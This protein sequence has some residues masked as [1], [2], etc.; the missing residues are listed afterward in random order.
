MIDLRN[1]LAFIQDAV[2]IEV[3]SQLLQLLAAHLFQAL[4]AD[5]V[6]LA[7]IDAVEERTVLVI[8]VA[9]TVDFGE[10]G[11]RSQEPAHRVNGQN[12][13]EHMGI[14]VTLA[15]PH[16]GRRQEAAPTRCCTRQLVADVERAPIGPWFRQMFHPSQCM[17]LEVWSERPVDGKAAVGRSVSKGVFPEKL[18]RLRRLALARQLVVVGADPG[19]D[20]RQ[21]PHVERD[22][23]LFQS[24]ER[25]NQE[26]R[27]GSAAAQCDGALLLPAHCIGHSNA[28]SLE[29]S[30]CW[31]SDPG[32]VW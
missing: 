12:V 7:E 5:Q 15:Y 32:S 10:E 16:L 25:A 30:C 29:G 1:L 9:E 6:E 2:A 23:A 4:V 26:T 14:H 27:R 20:A 13:V 21:G 24:T 8:D 3:H 11:C 28:P 19:A 17:V 31:R 22:A 18:Q